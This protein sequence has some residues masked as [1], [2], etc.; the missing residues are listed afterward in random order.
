MMPI[1]RKLLMECLKGLDLLLLGMAFTVG[2][3]LSYAPSGHISFSEFLAIR[4]KI[5]NIMFVGA[6][7]LFAHVIFSFLQLYESKRLSHLKDEVI[8][9][10]KGI[11]LISII[12]GISAIVFKVDIITQWFLLGF[13][14]VAVVL[15]LTSRLILRFALRQVRLNGRNVRNILIVGTNP[16]AV[17]FAQTIQNKPELGYRLVGFMDE[18][19]SGTTAFQGTGHKIVTDFQNL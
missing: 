4:V 11:S 7:A 6:M 13:W 16:R 2:V 3:V 14:L 12:L 1:R 19:W 8:D 5:E 10:L 17:Q 18:S 9:L 15:L